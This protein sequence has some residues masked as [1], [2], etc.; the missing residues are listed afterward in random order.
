MIGAPEGLVL[1]D[2]PAGLTSHDVVARVRRA[3]GQPSAGHAGTLDP[4]ATGLL[5]VVL[6][7]ATRLVRFLPRS[8]KLYTGILRLGATTTTDDL[9]GEVLAVHAGELPEPS[10]VL[11]AARRLTGTLLQR[12]PSVSARKLGGARLYRLARAGV[13]V[14][15]APRQV[16]VTRFELRPAGPPGEWQFEAEVSG[17]TYI[18]ALARDLGADLGCGGA[19]AGLRRIGI[20]P[21]RVDEARTLAAL[22]ALPP[23]AWCEATIPPERMPLVP[24]AVDLRDAGDVRRFTR[25]TPVPAPAPQSSRAGLWRVLDGSGRLLGVAEAVSGKLQPRVV[26]PLP[27]R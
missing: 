22:E 23:G 6:G 8:P 24:P 1:V 9:T 3:S 14:E 4:M 26:L 11:E 17:G 16:E 7:R 25:G 12:P 2:K 18:R 15:A 10:R 27:G 19:L 20:G 21:M 5:P 13:A